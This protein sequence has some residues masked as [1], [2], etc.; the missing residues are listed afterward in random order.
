MNNGNDF[1][2]NKPFKSTPSGTIEN[3]IMSSTVPKNEREW[4]AAREIA[5]LRAVI[6]AQASAAP[7]PVKAG[8]PRQASQSMRPGD[9]SYTVDRIP[10]CY[11]WGD[12]TAEL[13]RDGTGRNWIMQK[14]GSNIRHLNKYENNFVNSAISATTMAMLVHHAAAELAIATQSAPAEQPVV[15]GGWISVKD[16]LPELDYP[17]WL[18]DSDVGAF[19]GE[20]GDTGEGWLYGRSSH[21]YQDKN[22]AWLTSDCE[23]DDFNVSHWM[24]LPAAPSIPAPTTES[25]P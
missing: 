4:W 14:G 8:T 23:Q 18:F 21:F 10:V 1:L 15:A 11:P 25:K 2:E 5:Q 16:R 13:V 3:Q 6:A 19:I 22:G 20:R 12:L 17:V 7:V 24:P 9:P